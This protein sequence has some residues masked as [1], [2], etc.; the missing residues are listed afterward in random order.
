[1]VLVKKRGTVHRTTTKDTKMNYSNR[2]KCKAGQAMKLMI[3]AGISPAR[4]IQI[5]RKWIEDCET[6]YCDFVLA[7]I[8]KEVGE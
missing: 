2:P 7:E 4:A 5:K 8:R 6:E 3:E 1:M